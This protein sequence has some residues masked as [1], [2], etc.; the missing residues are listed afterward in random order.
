MLFRRGQGLPL[1]TVILAILVLLVL[2]IVGAIFG[3]QLGLF[4]QE[5]RTATGEEKECTTPRA[6]VDNCPPGTVESYD[7]YKGLTLTQKCCIPA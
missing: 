6:V 7:R 2:V 4:G 1:N 3:R 5:T